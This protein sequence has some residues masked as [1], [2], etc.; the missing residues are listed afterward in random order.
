MCESAAYILKDGKEELFLESVDFLENKD[1]HV[2][3]I[4]LFGEEKTITARV[5]VLSLVDHRIVLEP[6]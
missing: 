6:L 5:K 2:R 3:M 1:G 4:N